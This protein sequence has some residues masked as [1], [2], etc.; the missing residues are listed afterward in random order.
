MGGM[1]ATL[2]VTRYRISCA[3]EHSRGGEKN[4]CQPPLPPG[5]PA[6]AS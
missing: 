4:W 5:L 6:G 2:G 1:M 3:R